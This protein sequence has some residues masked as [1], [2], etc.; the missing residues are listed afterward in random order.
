MRFA[1]VVFLSLVAS[2]LTQLSAAYGQQDLSAR[3]R[4]ALPIIITR[5]ISAD[6]AHVGDVIY[7]KTTQRSELPNGISVPYRTRV[8]GHV[9]STSG[10]VKRNKLVYDD[11]APMSSLAVRF[12][13]IQLADETLPI[14][15]YVRAMADPFESDGARTPQ[16]GDMDPQSTTTQIG[17][18]LLTPS[19]KDVLGEDGRVVGH[20]LRHGIYARLRENGSC[21]GTKVE[22]SVGIYSGAACGLYG[23]AEVNATGV[24]TPNSR[25]VSLTSLKATAR[26]MRYSTALLEVT[27]EQ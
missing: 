18:D 11:V 2:P 23:F 5:D 24:G 4:T 22:V 20:N 6:N 9:V 25:G 15:A 12:D 3:L 17:G 26:V 21:T 8:L 16:L 1:K 27:S 7:A 10:P 19:Q 13:S 14:N